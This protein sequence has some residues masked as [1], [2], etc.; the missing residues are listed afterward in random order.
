MLHQ[1]MLVNM[2]RP[3]RQ[4]REER[5]QAKGQTGN[6]QIPLYAL[7]ICSISKGRVYFGSS[8]YTFT[9]NALWVF[10]NVQA[11]KW[12]NLS[13]CKNTIKKIKL[14]KNFAKSYTAK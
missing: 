7:T 1:V 12:K 9:Q 10:F 11:A 2:S 8:V 5:W 3:A 13:H 6:T 14:K 4:V